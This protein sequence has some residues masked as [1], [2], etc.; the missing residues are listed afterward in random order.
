MANWFTKQ[1]SRLFSRNKKEAPKSGN[2]EAKLLKEHSERLEK[3]RSE[4]K[5]DVSEAADELFLEKLKTAEKAIEAKEQELARHREELE[6][7]TSTGT[8]GMTEQKT[9]APGTP[10]RDGR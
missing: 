5:A 1:F 4:N 9:P 8:A 6:S 7:R 3:E 10:S 2:D